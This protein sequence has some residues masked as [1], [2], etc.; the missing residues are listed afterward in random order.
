MYELPFQDA[1]VNA[2]SNNLRNNGLNAVSFNF[3]TSSTNAP[4]TALSTYITA[5][6][7][8]K[9]GEGN[10]AYFE[11]VDISSFIPQVESL[12]ENFER[13]SNVL[14]HSLPRR[15]TETPPEQL[16]VTNH[17]LL[18]ETTLEKNQR[19]LNES[20]CCNLPKPERW[21]PKARPRNTSKKGR[22]WAP[23]MPH[24]SQRCQFRRRTPEPRYQST[25]EKRSLI[26]KYPKTSEWYRKPHEERPGNL[27]RGTGPPLNSTL[28]SVMIQPYQPPKPTLINQEGISED[29]NAELYDV[30]R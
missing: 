29:A 30:P 28:G 20:A 24:V 14:E 7:T 13:R 3:V 22:G 9:E 2:Q 1:P 12:E 8:N 5:S 21:T 11:N 26:P 19:K 4:T 18:R 6:A 15:S 27:R 25:A 10:R 16:K 17:V 23:W